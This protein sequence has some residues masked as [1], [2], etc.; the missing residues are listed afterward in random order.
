M[1]MKNYRDFVN[2]AFYGLLAFMSSRVVNSIDTLNTE[3]A[4]VVT[5]I[6]YH[7]KDLQRHDAQIQ[8]IKKRIMSVN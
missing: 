7:E 8:E 4:K 3:M 6:G 1:D 5:A 2:W